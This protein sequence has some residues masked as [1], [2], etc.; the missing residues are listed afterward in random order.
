MTTQEIQPQSRF[1]Y[2]YIVVSASLVIVTIA[3]GI[4]YS[5]GVFFAPLLGEFG[6]TRAMTSGALSLSTVVHIP[7]LIVVGRLTDR[8][9]PRLVL[10]ACGFFLGLG[11]L[12]MSQTNAIW[13]LYLFYG[14]IA[15]IGMG[16]YWVPIISIIPRWFIKKRGLMMAI[17]TSGVG[18]G[19]LVVPPLAN[20][21]ISIYGWR[22]SYLIIGSITMGV[23]MLAAQFLKQHPIQMGQL[24][25]NENKVE[26]KNSVG[27]VD[28]LSIRAAVH[29]RPFWIASML[30]LSWGFC[31]SIVMVH[32]VIHA[33][34]LGMSP[35]SAANILAIIG[36]AGIA[37]RLAFGRIADAIGMKPI[38]IISMSL[39][40]ISFLCLLTG[41]EMWV[42]YLFAA[43]FGI[44][45]GTMEI[46]QSPIM[47]NLFGLSSLATLMGL[48]TAIG[49]I[50]FVVGPVLGGY[51]FDV[52]GSYHIVFIICAAM[53][54][55]C[56]ML[57]TLL[58]LTRDKEERHYKSQL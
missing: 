52:T 17:V 26:E 37:G 55:I 33:I 3:E 12:L 34:G 45:Y 18:I 53:A 41:T 25:Y 2:G 23:I 51:I 27:K 43:I 24:P 49:A 9:G 44:S 1:S 56:I 47:A 50:G 57:S 19:Q 42:L 40:S 14:V 48:N 4:L 22:K 32:S 7:I 35:A 46:L 28:G 6:W 54:M 31:L 30:L 20:W 11:Y 39:I 13:Q 10:S 5:F 15:S 58:P 21:L 8:F 36:G 38:L 29:T 16:F